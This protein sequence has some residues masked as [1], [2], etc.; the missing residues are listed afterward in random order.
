MKLANTPQ[1]PEESPTDKARPLGKSLHHMT[2]RQFTVCKW[3]HTPLIS[4]Y[5][6]TI[7]LVLSGTSVTALLLFPFDDSTFGKKLAVLVVALFYGFVGIR[8]HIASITK[9]TDPHK[10]MLD[11]NG[12][13][14]LRGLVRD[15]YTAIKDVTTVVLAQKEDGKDSDDALGIQTK[16]SGGKLMLPLF[17]ER[18]PFLKALKAIHPA[19]VV[20]TV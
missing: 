16:F 5:L 17:S 7:G 2:V 9:W 3:W 18:E 20:E 13:L 8:C 14:I 4:L 6:M 12:D 1:G 15:Q 11:E 19:I 10:L